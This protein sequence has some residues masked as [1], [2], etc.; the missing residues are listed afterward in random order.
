M[1]GDWESWNLSFI[2]LILM[3]AGLSIRSWLE[4]NKLSVLSLSDL[5]LE[6]VALSLDN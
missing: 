1:G 3:Q 6:E 2:V 4:A 5:R